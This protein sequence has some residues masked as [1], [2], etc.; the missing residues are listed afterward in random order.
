MGLGCDSYNDDALLRIEEPP[1]KMSFALPACTAL[2]MAA[3]AL[4]AVAHEVI[5]AAPLLGSSEV[6]AV[7]T[8]GT[9]NGVVTLD[10]DLL[11]MRVQASF[12]NLIGNTSAA[13]IH[14]CVLPGSNVGV[15]TQT[16]TFVDFPLG[17]TSGTYDR[18]FDMTLSSSY[19]S[20]FI[21]NNGGTV[22]SAFSALVAGL[23]GGRA[24]LNLH[25]TAFP[26]GEIR[27]LLVPVPEVSTYAMML[28]GLVGIGA[29]RRLRKTA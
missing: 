28:A 27:G 13:H 6:P 16:P 11:T 12:S 22:S 19:S 25:T 24:Y 20:A 26:G 10:L 8:T 5:Y 18:T 21:T 7:S 17:V 23:D 15:A 4:P 9:G 3:A 14:C 2:A 1:M 29:A